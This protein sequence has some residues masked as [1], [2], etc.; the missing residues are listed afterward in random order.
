MGSRDAPDGKPR[1]TSLSFALRG[2]R[3]LSPPP[4]WIQLQRSARDE[5]AA[6]PCCFTALLFEAPVTSSTIFLRTSGGESG[7]YTRP[8]SSYLWSENFQNDVMF[9]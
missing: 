8:W 3:Y 7:R 1:A 5:W 6:E 2:L 9:S 4:A